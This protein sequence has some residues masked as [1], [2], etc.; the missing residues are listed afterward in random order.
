M[1]MAYSKGS[2][3]MKEMG[4]NF[5]CPIC[6]DTV[7]KPRMLP[8]Q[9]VF[10][11]ECLRQLLDA[12]SA[13]ENTVKCSVCCQET[14]IPPKRE[15]G[16]PIAF[17]Q[18]N[19]VAAYLK[20]LEE[21]QVNKCKLHQEPTIVFCEQCSK[22]ICKSCKRDTH[23]KHNIIPLESAQK[24]HRKIIVNVKSQYSDKMDIYDQCLSE[25]KQVIQNMTHQKEDGLQKIEQQKNEFIAG[26]I[27]Q[28]NR[29][30]NEL[31]ETA[32]TAIA[33]IKSYAEKLESEKYCLSQHLEFLNK[34][35]DDG[36]D[37]EVIQTSLDHAAE[38]QENLKEMQAAK[39][40]SIYSLVVTCPPVCIRAE[41]VATVARQVVKPEIDS[42]RPLV[43]MAT[44]LR[45]V[46]LEFNPSGVDYTP[47]GNIALCMEA[48]PDVRVIS[49]YG[50]LVSSMKVPANTK[51]WD[52]AC[53]K[54]HIFVTN[55]S[56]TTESF[57]VYNA[58]GAF[59]T[60]QKFS[61]LKKM[62]G[63]SVQGSKMYIVAAGS[64][65]VLEIKLSEAGKC[66]NSKQFAEDI[67]LNNPS[68]VCAH[69]DS[70]AI[71]S[72]NDHCVYVTSL[73]GELRFT[74]GTP[75]QEGKTNNRLHFPRGVAFDSESRLF[76]ADAVNS[77]I[78]V[79]SDNG[80]FLGQI[81]MKKDQLKQ[82][83]GLAF[84][85]DGNLLVACSNPHNVA[86]Y[87]YHFV[88]PAVSAACV[89]S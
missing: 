84:D 29:L 63:V 39:P 56:G 27:S 6:L 82:P 17:N 14:E 9:H 80:T 42:S 31:K 20:M 30:S 35:L 70:V 4:E 72:T 36:T 76:I 83:R 64:N 40:P 26:F 34:Y 5:K 79:V 44:K 37:T 47:A 74:H 62:I 7:K 11:T 8:C 21:K 13:V 10:C 60:S 88:R 69:K 86:T 75:G 46:K 61:K 54:K 1:N 50:R 77:R 81:D 3:L 71:S 45:Q 55:S 23:K 49:P 2:L 78:C 16:F 24:T 32:G 15:M 53:T 38:F 73:S 33:E 68:F 87:E 22:I 51:A 28:A 12:C 59:L 85:Q 58:Q 57:Q 52:V 67:K 41:D 19:L 18:E 65:Q 89:I 25:T 43:L 48:G 66:M